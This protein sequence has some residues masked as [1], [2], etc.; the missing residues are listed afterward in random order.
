[1]WPVIAKGTLYRIHGD[2]QMLGAH[3]VCGYMG[4]QESLIVLNLSIQH[5]VFF[6]V[7]FSVLQKTSKFCCHAYRVL[8]TLGMTCHHVSQLTV[9]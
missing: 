2:T 8:K 4:N 3:V 1:M 6:C 7:G 9:S 5:F